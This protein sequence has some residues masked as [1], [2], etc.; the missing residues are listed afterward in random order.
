MSQTLEK[1]PENHRRNHL[2]DIRKAYVLDAARSVFETEGL[3]GASV[4][5]IAKKAGYTPGAIYSYFPSKEAIYAALLGESLERLK[6][7]V[8]IAKPSPAVIQSVNLSPQARQLAGKTMAW[9]KFYNSN[10]RYL[11]LGFYL[12]KGMRPRGLTG[13]LNTFLNAQLI[14]ALEPAEKALLEMGLP[15]E[16]ALSENTATF[17]HGVGLL[18]LQHTGRIKLFKQNA[19]ELFTTYIVQLC[20]RY[21]PTQEQTSTNVAATNVEEEFLARQKPLW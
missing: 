13:D 18:L 7:A 5:E 2:I 3:D 4:R 21:A 19:D 12:F 14:Q 20:Q 1:T 17:A 10:P 8:I 9:F 15:E 6:I 16:L 11:D